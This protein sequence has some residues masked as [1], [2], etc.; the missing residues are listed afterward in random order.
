MVWSGSEGNSNGRQDLYIAKLKNPWTI[1][2]N[3]AKISHPE[4]GSEHHGDLNNPHNS[5]P[6][7]M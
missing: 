1:E 5:L 4:H 7:S 3:R 2:G 6:M